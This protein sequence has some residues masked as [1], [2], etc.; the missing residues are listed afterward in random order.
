MAV[1]CSLDIFYCAVPYS[2]ADVLEDRGPIHKELFRQ[3]WQALGEAKQVGLCAYMHARVLAACSLKG[4]R[5][6]R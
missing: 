3:Q 4:G 6:Q 2:V 1:K 5:Q